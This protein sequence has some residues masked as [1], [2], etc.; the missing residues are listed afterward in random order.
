MSVIGDN[1]KQIRNKR[2]LTQKQL[3]ERSSVIETTI[4][5]YELGITVPKT[6]NLKK[7]AA[8][9][10]VPIT[11]LTAETTEQTP[12]L[13]SALRE[14]RLRRSLTIDDIALQLGISKN[15]VDSWE[16]GISIPDIISFLQLCYYSYGMKEAYSIAK[17]LGLTDSALWDFN[18]FN[19]ELTSN[20]KD[21]SFCPYCGKELLNDNKDL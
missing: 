20:T 8:A 14:Q 21:F 19:D 17:Q 10:D 5:K 15:V 11:S 4:R 9:L 13:G 3:S 2:K 16:E 18:Q 6:E 1:I 12:I 7:I